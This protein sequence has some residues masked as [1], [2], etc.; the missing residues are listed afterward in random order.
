MTTLDL[1]TAQGRNTDAPMARAAVEFTRSHGRLPGAGEPELHTWLERKRRAARKGQLNAQLGAWL[2]ENLPGWANSREDRWKAS[3][4]A[5]VAAR[6][7]GESPDR[8]TRTWLGTQ[9]RAAASGKLAPER[10]RALQDAFGGWLETPP[11]RMAT[12]DERAD[13]VTDFVDLHG[14]LPSLTGRDDEVSLARWLTH[15]RAKARAGKLA[16]SR[17]NRLDKDAPG[18]LP[19]AEGRDFPWQTKARAL[20]GFVAGTGRWP[21]PSVPAEAALA[22]WAR[23]QRSAHRTG[24]LTA[25]RA[26]HLEA[27]PGW[28]DAAIAKGGTI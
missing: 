15:Q 22:A 28:P 14:R 4:A 2:D 6:T 19:L 12:W 1:P 13:D 20:A 23:S 3:L 10:R 21:V 11:R 9:R 25:E 17:M 27:I 7:A 16:S 26:G 24:R 8:A 5:A 18:W